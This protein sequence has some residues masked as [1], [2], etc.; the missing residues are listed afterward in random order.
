MTEVTSHLHP[1]R[2]GFHTSS[3]PHKNRTAYLNAPDE[4][5][6]GVPK[7]LSNTADSTA[8]S[9]QVAIGGSRYILRISLFF[10]S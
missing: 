4:I 1:L 8:Y 5:S 6:V 9:E 7:T 10:L 3:D 2:S